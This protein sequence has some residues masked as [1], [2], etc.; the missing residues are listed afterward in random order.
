[1]NWSDL[2]NLPVRLTS[3]L[4]P[5]GRVINHYTKLYNHGRFIGKA[6]ES[7]LSQSYRSLGILIID[8]TSDDETI[9]VIKPLRIN[10]NCAGGLNLTVDRWKLLIKALR[11]L[12]VRSEQSKVP[13]TFTSLEL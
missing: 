9:D 6:I 5:N 1:M 4:L 11:V 13:M 12:M 3:F 7:I 10:H 8:G 2:E